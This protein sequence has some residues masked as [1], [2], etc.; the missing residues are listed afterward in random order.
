MLVAA[1]AA[2]GCSKDTTSPGL[3][4]TLS[5][6]RRTV[7]FREDSLRLTTDSVAVGITGTGAGTAGWVATHGGGTWLTLTS[8]QGT[9]NGMLRWA[10]DTTGLTDSVYVDTITVTL[11]VPGGA[12][13]RLVD[14]LIVRG[15]PAQYISVRRAWLPG[16]RDATAAYV[17]AARAWDDFS[18]LAP[19]AFATWDSTTDIILNPLW[20][21]AGAAPWRTSPPARAPM[22]PLFAA[23]WSGLGMDILIAFDSVPGGTIQRDSLNWIT[24]RWWNPAD[25]TWKGWIIRGT[26]ATTFTYQTVNTT[27][28][29]ATGDHTGV[30]AGEARLASG[31]YWEGNGGQYRITS[32]G[33]YGTR[34]TIPSGP[35][36]GGNVQ[37]GLMGGQLNAVTM[38]RVLGT[39]TPTTKTINW[40]FRAATLN[41]LRIYCYFTPL[42]PPT[43][44]TSCTGSAFANIVAAARA[45]RLTAAMAA[46][47]ADSLFTALSPRGTRRATRRRHRRAFRSASC[48]RG[49]ETRRR[50]P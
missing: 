8:A 23:G 44:Y 15:A 26:T 7:S 46:G 47:L 24:V 41:S 16:E 30:G 10:R 50:A 34:T 12:A 19:A 5:A 1:A 38:P 33:S 40:D 29:N 25:S 22:S 32:N 14:S 3:A 49:N 45:H 18:D 42:T 35:Y 36:K 43:G 2:T 13:V 31:S 37:S 39:D 21:P 4:L 6:T 9:G 17:L 11:Q 27:A 20:N 28:F 48:G